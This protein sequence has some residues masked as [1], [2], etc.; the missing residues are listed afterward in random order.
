MD[1][2]LGIQT[3]YASPEGERLSAVDWWR[4]VNPLQQIAKNT[5]TK[6]DFMT[7]VVKEGEEPELAWDKIGQY[8]IV[9]SSYIDNPKSYAYMKA[10]NQKYG[11]KFIMDLDDDVFDID[12]FNPARIKYYDGS[13]HLEVLTKIIS[14]VDYMTTSTPHLAHSVYRNTGTL[15][16][17]MP[18]YIDPITY[19]YTDSVD[20]HDG[21]YIGY[22]GSS[23]HMSDLFKT[24]VL[25]ALRRLTKEYDVKVV[26]VGCLID[27]I[28]DII[29]DAIFISGERDHRKWIKLWNKMPIDIGIAPLINTSFNRSKSS[30]KYFE[31]SLRKIP[32]VYSWVDPY[33]SVVREN[34][35]GFLAQSEL[36]W[37]E[38]LKRL[39][40]D[41][42]LREKIAENAREDVLLHYRIQDHWERLYNYFKDVR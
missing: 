11:T 13:K 18:N 17:V 5:D 35:T 23:T 12:E 16:F 27:E 29:P 30:I 33:I 36:E 42:S 38:K 6:V 41:T 31:Y 28:K 10:I 34:R 9:Y 40:E 14:D 22:Q 26:F 20:K 7:K 24:G 21:I 32:A 25:Y 1:S 37:Y 39:I 19:Q 3:H 4:I 8:D 2:I 15:P